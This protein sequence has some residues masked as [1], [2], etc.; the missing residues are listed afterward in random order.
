[1]MTN[2]ATRLINLIMLLQRQP[3][4][5]A[6]DL[7]DELGVSIRTV[8]RYFGMLEEL[9]I[10]L[11]S[12]RGPAGG[13]SLVRGYKMPPLVLNPEEAVAVGLGTSLVEEMWG[14]LYR[15]AARG[16]LAKLDNLLP[17]EQRQEITWARRALI[18]TQLHKAGQQ[19][20]EGVLDK[21]RS[22][23]HDSQRVRVTYEN[24]RDSE[25]TIRDFDP[26]ALVHRWGR[27]YIAGFCHLRGAL[28]L[29]R[30]DRIRELS[31]SNESFIPPADFDARAFLAAELQPELTIQARVRFAP[32]AA[33]FVRDT[34]IGWSEIE[35]QPDGSLLATLPASDL[36]FAAS[37]LI[38]F[39][40]AVTILEPEEL[41]QMVAEWAR[42]L[43]ERYPEQAKSTQG[44]MK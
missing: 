43:L 13:F 24:P 42:M 6:G 10:P 2:S 29:L 34:S 30:L 22:A 15:D 17:D 8:H 12:E 16:A 44:E 21:L 11:Y 31:V 1:M 38:S 39:G 23:L 37:M 32:E 28:R 36:V 40:P 9:G 7:A 4:R 5:K 25:P 18:A 35:V 3:N 20:E 19:A 26:Y 27:W 14:R 33:G 41:K